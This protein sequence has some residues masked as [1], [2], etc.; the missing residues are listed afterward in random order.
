[1]I[2]ENMETAVTAV[3]ATAY[4]VRIVAWTVLTA[5]DMDTDRLDWMMESCAD[6]KSMY[7]WNKAIVAMADGRT[8]GCIVSY[9][10]DDYAALR[11]YTWPRLWQDADPETI[12]NSAVEAF[13]GE[14]Y[15]D[16][17]AV[18]P[19]YRGHDIGRILIEAAMERGR[20]LGYS[21]FTLLVDCHKQ[22][23]QRYYESLGFREIGEVMFFGYR[24][25][26]M[27]REDK[28]LSHKK[29]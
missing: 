26:R 17:L 18:L 4:D 15:L 2:E 11:Q 21:R 27:L 23:L 29:C 10:G 20:R 7:S 19:E 16:S 1:M 9:S 12:R 13:P 8:V 22:R 5:L 24:Y 3:P 25:K 28:S 14:Y 6:P